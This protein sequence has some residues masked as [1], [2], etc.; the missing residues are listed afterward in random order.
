MDPQ[1]LAARVR[2]GHVSRVR[3]GF[4]RV[5]RRTVRNSHVDNWGERIV[6]VGRRFRLFRRRLH[7][8]LRK[9]GPDAVH[10]LRGGADHA[11]PRAGHRPGATLSQQAA[12]CDSQYGVVPGKR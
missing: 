3:R 5:R 10:L 2:R 12:G 11:P 6:A 7:T 9:P 4:T 1:Y 8:R